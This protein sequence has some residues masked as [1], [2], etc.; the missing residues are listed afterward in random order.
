MNTVQYFNPTTGE[1]SVSTLGK[2]VQFELQHFFISKLRDCIARHPQVADS[3]DTSPFLWEPLES[4]VPNCLVA[5]HPLHHDGKEAV[6]SFTISFSAIGN[7]KKTA[8]STLAH[9]MTRYPNIQT[10]IR[11]DLGGL[12]TDTPANNDH[13]ERRIQRLADLSSV[14]TWTRDGHGKVV[15]TSEKLSKKG[16]ELRLCLGGGNQGD[17]VEVVVKYSE[18]LDAIRKGGRKFP[19]GG[20]AARG[21]ASS[22][23]LQSSMVSLLFPFPGRHRFPTSS[24]MSIEAVRAA[25]LRGLGDTANTTTLTSADLGGR[26]GAGMF[27]PRPYTAN[28]A[29]IAG[30]LW[31]RLLVSL[32]RKR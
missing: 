30:S 9:L 29:G 14:V 7:K 23:P 27:R 16:G 26:Q 1:M 17:G 4:K 28:R 18:I 13:H 32:L 19:L 3:L 2:G 10:M 15:N 11:L 22:P 20:V 24:S 25:R 31:S 21:D 12:A 5:V 8:Q 6:A